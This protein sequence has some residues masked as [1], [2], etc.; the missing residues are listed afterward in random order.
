M[1][2]EP[3]K[4]DPIQGAIIHV[5]DGIEEADN[6][7]PLW[8]V[9][10]FLGSIAFAFAYWLAFEVYQ[11]RPSPHQEYVAHAQAIEAARAAELAASPDVSAELLEELAEQDGAVAQG[12][13][14]YVAQCVPCHGERAEGKIGPNLTDGSWLHGGDALAIHTT[15]TTGVAAKG[16]PALGSILGP[17]AVREVTAY[18][19]SLRNTNV[20]GGKAPEGVATS[21]EQSAL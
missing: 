18:V 11:V 20:A 2:E 15:I 19:L 21:A 12:K 4:H 8:W 1:V 9:A 10:G 5:Y 3:Q 13:S 14:V 7:L 6:Q 17:K 16:M